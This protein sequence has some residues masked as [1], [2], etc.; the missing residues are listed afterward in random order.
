[1][2]E[3]LFLR[4][5]KGEN[6]PIGPTLSLCAF[7][8]LY[9]IL[10]TKAVVKIDPNLPFGRLDFFD[11]ICPPNHPAVPFLLQ[12]LKSAGWESSGK[13]I[14]GTLRK[15]YF[16]LKIKR[17]YEKR[18]LEKIS[19]FSVMSWGDYPISSLS[20]RHGE[21]WCARADIVD[22]KQQNG[23][24]GGELSYFVDPAVKNRMESELK[25][26]LFH[27]LEWDEQELAKHDYWEV[28]TPLSMPPCLLP[29]VPMDDLT[30][31]EEENYWPPELSFNRAQVQALGDFDLA[32]GRE[33]VGR[34]GPQHGNHL[35]IVSQ[36]FR[37]L[38][39][40]LRLSAQFTPVRLVD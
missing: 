7:Q 8:E 19:F 16:W 33:W 21:R 18:E 23:S 25:G 32:W 17:I 24:I 11:E 39:L 5:R 4:I 10:S 26:V 3:E 1:M 12:Y 15:N 29:V 40:S 14:S 34:K 38:C 31:Y 20:E 13:F 30:Y 36:K 2:K 27:R 28:D 35:L 9:E 6:S 37:K 22:W